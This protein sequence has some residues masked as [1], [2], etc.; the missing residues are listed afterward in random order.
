M[1]SPQKTQEYQNNFNAILRVK[2]DNTH[3]KLA[4]S[5]T[6]HWTILKNIHVY[7]L[8]LG[9]GPTALNIA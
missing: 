5:F 8:S 9:V 3:I 7:P 6:E 4:V 1:L 2:F